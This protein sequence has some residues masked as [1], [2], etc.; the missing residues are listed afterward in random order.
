MK[1]FMALY[2]APTAAIDEMMQKM[3]PEEAQAGMAEWT[4]WAE[5]HT[6][7]ISD[8]G[9]PLGKNKRVTVGG[10]IDQRNEVAGYSFVEAETHGAAAQ[11]FTDSPHLQIP[12][13]YIDIVECVVM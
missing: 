3:T 2:M 6:G 1:K 9:M 7:E 5:R 12:G 8:L 11:I 10:V 4:K 13:A